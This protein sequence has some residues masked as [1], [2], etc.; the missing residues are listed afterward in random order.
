[1]LMKGIMPAT[2]YNE[3]NLTKGVRVT[4]DI[5]SC[6]EHLPK[7][8]CYLSFRINHENE[9]RFHLHNLSLSLA[10]LGCD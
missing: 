3:S 10:A 6:F 1:M 7:P 5:K 8:C 9:S 4:K 2:G